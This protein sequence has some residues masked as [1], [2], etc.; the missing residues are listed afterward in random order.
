MNVSQREALRRY[1]LAHR[2]AGRTPEAIA[3]DLE[4]IEH[5][6]A[7]LIAAYEAAL[8]TFKPAPPADEQ[9]RQTRE[10][11]HQGL[12]VELWRFRGLCGVCGKM[13]R[14]CYEA[15]VGNLRYLGRQRRRRA[16]TSGFS[17]FD[18]TAASAI[19]GAGAPR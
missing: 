2:A 4:Q 15:S 19:G 11:A 14:A 10:T 1:V 7:A 17:R 12:R 18:S 6:H 13:L 8:A 5:S 9:W 3:A 16:L